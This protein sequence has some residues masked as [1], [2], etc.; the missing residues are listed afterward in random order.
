MYIMTAAMAARPYERGTITV[1]FQ[2]LL[3]KRRRA[4][5]EIVRQLV[6][7]RLKSVGRVSAVLYA[8]TSVQVWAKCQINRFEADPNITMYCH[9]HN[10]TVTDNV[11]VNGMMVVPDDGSTIHGLSWQVEQNTSNLKYTG[12]PTS[13][14]A[15][16]RE[17]KV[18][19]G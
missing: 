17:C 9:H 12:K 13:V 1:H 2:A 15:C 16:S 14:S 4:K 3:Y 11:P 19:T 7:P 8:S 18:T 5:R 6:F 10:F